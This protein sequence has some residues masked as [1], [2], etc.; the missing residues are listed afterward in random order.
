MLSVDI[1]V[2]DNN[3]YPKIAIKVIYLLYILINIFTAFTNK[4]LF[5]SSLKR[6]HS[7]LRFKNNTF[8]F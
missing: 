2:K 4:S 8:A 3:L 6:K 7:I 1:Q 5:F